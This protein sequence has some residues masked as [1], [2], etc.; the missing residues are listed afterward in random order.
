ME[1]NWK[2][3]ISRM[4]SLGLNREQIQI[5]GQTDLPF[6]LQ[7]EHIIRSLLKEI[8]QKNEDSL[9]RDLS[10]IDYVVIDSETTG[11][12]PDKGDEIISL[13]AVKITNGKIS[14]TVFFTYLSPTH[15]IPTKI[16]ELTGIDEKVIAHAP[17]IEEVIQEFL[18]F[19]GQSWIVGFHI[20]HDLT[21]LNDFLLKNYQ[22]KIDRSVFEIQQVLQV[23]IPNHMLKSLDEAL[24]YYSIP[25]YQRHHALDDSIMIANLWLKILEECKK[26]GI[27][28]LF[29]L[30]SRIYSI[31]K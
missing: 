10:S 6:S 1:P 29:D 5:I 22:S 13:S 21:F 18:T 20:N 31:S 19:I 26:K 15:P 24:D 17:K 30:Y 12:F 2:H 23:V 9:R 8:R 27:I 25:I 7:Q 3:F 14:P 16:R 28:T 11:F 4:L